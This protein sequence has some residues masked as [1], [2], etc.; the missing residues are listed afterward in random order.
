MV[1]IPYVNSCCCIAPKRVKLVHRL[2][3]AMSFSL[4]H[5]DLQIDRLCC[6]LSRAKPGR[7]TLRVDSLS[8][9]LGS[10]IGSTFQN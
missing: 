6:N 1:G 7:C 9:V 2:F 8:D 3:E 4:T 10:T 5:F